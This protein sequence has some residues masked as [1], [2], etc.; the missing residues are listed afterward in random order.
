MVQKLSVSSGI[1]ALTNQHLGIIVQK[2]AERRPVQSEL[3]KVSEKSINRAHLNSEP[4]VGNAV[5]DEMY[6]LDITGGEIAG[7]A[8]LIKGEAKV[9]RY[10]VFRT[11]RSDEDIEQNKFQLVRKLTNASETHLFVDECYQVFF[12]RPADSDGLANYVRMLKSKHL[13]P[14][15]FMKALLTSPEGRN[16]VD[17]LVIVPYPSPQ[18]ERRNP[19]SNRLGMTS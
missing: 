4:S 9:E 13:S 3:A 16:H 19:Q 5:E 17:T 7:R 6:I 11:A 15:D 14:R 18:L 2:L 10:W 12:E 8:I 1:S